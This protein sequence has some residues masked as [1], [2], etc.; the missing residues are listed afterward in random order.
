MVRDD[1][2]IFISFEGQHRVWTYR[3]IASEAAW[4]PRH[5]DFKSMQANSSLEALA[6][7]PDGALYTIPERSGRLSLAFPVYR[8]KGGVWTNAFTLPRRGKFLV[9]GADFGPD[10]NLYLLERY[11]TGLFGFQT[12][13]RRFRLSGS[14]ITGEEIILSTT[15]GR[16]D[17]L[18]GLTVWR[19]SVGNLRLTMI[20]DDNFKSF[21]RIELVE[22]LLPK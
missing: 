18:E 20:S 17:N 10:G 14:K 8:Y 11:F 4:L 9:V 16:H 6:I 15:T 12:R 7:G 22:Y 5:A 13:V 2:R 19:D 21:Q 1:G 3:D